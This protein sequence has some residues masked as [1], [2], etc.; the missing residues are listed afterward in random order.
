MDRKMAMILLRRIDLKGRSWGFPDNSP[1]ITLI[2]SNLRLYAWF[3]KCI[4]TR[5]IKEGE[6]LQPRK[7]GPPPA[8]SYISIPAFT[9]FLDNF[10][11]FP[12]SRLTYNFFPFLLLVFP[13]QAIQSFNRL[14]SRVN[15]VK[16]FVL[17]CFVKV[18]WVLKIED[19]ELWI[20]GINL[21]KEPL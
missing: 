7:P 3:R 4:N 19:K 10:T 13:L 11:D 16:E 6:V 17:E 21:K 2:I 8:F 14:I 1:Q 18:V 20:T 12:R 15:L 9:T 5:T